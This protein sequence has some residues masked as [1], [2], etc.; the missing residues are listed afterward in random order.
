MEPIQDI[1]L[2]FIRIKAFR[3]NDQCFIDL[4][5]K[6]IIKQTASYQEVVNTTGWSRF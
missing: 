5:Y 2:E 1:S 3:I 6:Y 4:R